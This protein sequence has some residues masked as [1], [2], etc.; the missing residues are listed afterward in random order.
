MV[1]IRNRLDRACVSIIG[2]D[3]EFFL[4]NRAFPGKKTSLGESLAKSRAYNSI[5][6]SGETLD[7]REKSRQESCR[8][9]HQESSR[10]SPRLSVRLLARLL[11]RLFT[12]ARVSDQII[13]MALRKTLSESRFFTRVVLA[14]PGS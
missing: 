11:A 9:S 6:D 13:C 2:P 10:L 8:E 14:A 1:I 5:W 4:A 12:L 7:E 3:G